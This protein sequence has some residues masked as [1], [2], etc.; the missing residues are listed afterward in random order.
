MRIHLVNPSPVSFGTAVITPRWLYVLAG[1]TPSSFGTPIIADETLDPFDVDT[2]RAGDVVGIG[3]HTGNALRGYEIGRA[4]RARGATVVFGGIHSTLYPDE[5]R[6]RGGAH[7]V[8]K[9][10]GDLVWPRVLADAAGGTVYQIYDGGRIE[11]NAFVAARWDLLPPDRYMWGSVQTIRGCPKHC[12]FCS[13]WRTDGQKPRQ[14]PVDEVVSEVIALRRLGFR[15]ILLSDDNFYPVPLADLA[16]ADRRA[17]RSHIQ[18]LDALRRERFE[19]MSRLE[20]LPDDLVFYTQITMEAAEDPEFLRAMRRAR[21]RGALVGIESVTPDGLKAV[22]KDFN[23]AGEALV[24][25]LRAFS[26]NGVHVLGSF[27]FGLPTD[28]PDTFA[29]TADLAQRAGV[30]FAQFVMLQ[31]FPGTVDFARWERE[32]AAAIEVE[33]VPLARYWLIPPDKRPKIYMPHP[34]MSAEDIRRLT[35]ATWDEFYRLPLI[36]KR[37]LGCVKSMKARLAF[38]LISK[39]YR[40][41]YANTGI[42]TDSARVARSARR[43]RVLA[44]FAR[45]LFVTTPMPN[46]TIPSRESYPRRPIDAATAEAAPSRSQLDGATSSPPSLRMRA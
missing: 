19:L 32:P 30:S 26:E 41:M 43:A 28:R 29:A 23:Q 5:A 37:S 39:L 6:D 2:V 14:R 9:G 31:P 15:F 7:A 3:I 27:I 11:G 33:G 38:V 25:R 45:R 24:T 1:A 22:F 20:E 42:A 36:W 4:A 16:A 8:V 46:L 12:S 18:K 35:Q 10:D 40:Q 13:V 44:A 21:I 17:D 34:A